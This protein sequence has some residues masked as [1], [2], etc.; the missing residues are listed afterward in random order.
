MALLNFQ[1]KLKVNS[2]KLKA[3]LKSKKDQISKRVIYPTIEGLHINII[4]SKNVYNQI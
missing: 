3:F 2:E 1:K 4:P